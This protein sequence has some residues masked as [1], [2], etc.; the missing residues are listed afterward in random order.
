MSKA[1]ANFQLAELIPEIGDPLVSPDGKTFVRAADGGHATVGMR[2]K[3]VLSYDG[4]TIFFNDTAETDTST[5]P[6]AGSSTDPKYFLE[7]GVSAADRV[8]KNGFLLLTVDSSNI[9]M[10]YRGSATVLTFTS[11]TYSGG[12]IERSGTKQGVSYSLK[13]FETPAEGTYTVAQK[14]DAGT[15]G[16]IPKYN[17]RGVLIDSGKNVTDFALAA[18]SVSKSTTSTQSIASN[19]LLPNS[20]LV[21]GDGVDFI[22]PY[23]QM[24]LAD[25][26]GTLD[27][28][29]VWLGD[30]TNNTGIAATGIVRLYESND[31]FVESVFLFPP[32]DGNVTKTIAT[33]DQIPSIPSATSS[34]VSK[35]LGVTDS[36]GTLGWVPITTERYTISTPTQTASGTTVSL[37]LNDKSINQVELAS[38]V[39][40]ATISF[41][42]K[43]T[44]YARDFFVRLTITGTTVPA[45]TWQEAN[46]DP[47][48]FDVDD[49][50]WEEIE[51][52]VNIL[53]FTETRQSTSGA[54]V[55]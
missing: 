5:F 55:L 26:S 24:W 18:D 20:Q 19:L 27:G 49:E 40:A 47:I 13:V 36:S 25:D 28:G 6:S 17:S 43:V 37:T 42:A 8:S 23:I 29:Q 39:T 4:E 48:D 7:H 1:Y 46:G 41:P 44:G 54:A 11:A 2:C 31:S 15:S 32:T 22:D 34:D 52:G 51:Q 50:S 9:V 10:V 33:T 35:I 3:A 38:T 16:D 30:G 21:V 12:V 14:L 45:I 53:M